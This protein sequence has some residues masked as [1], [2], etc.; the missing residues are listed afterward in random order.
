MDADLIVIGGGS[1]GVR[2]ARVA[3]EHG[4]KVVIAEAD[5]W[6]GTCVIRGCI[7]KKL[8]V[9]AAALG[10]DIEDAR[11]YGW[12][13]GEAVNDMAALAAAVGAE[14]ERL[15]QAY[16]GRLER[17][18][19]RLVRGRA[20]VVGP[21]EVEVDGARVSAGVILVAT[22][23]S[24]E[25]LEGPGC[26][27]AIDSDDVFRMRERPARLAVVGGGYIAVELAHVFRGLGSAVHLIHRGAQMLR[28]FDADVRAAVTEGLGARGIALHLEQTLAAAERTGQPVRPEPFG[29]AQDRLRRAE[30]PAESKDGP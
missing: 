26:D 2:A 18:G 17:A 27:V 8:M 3:A 21:H 22:G 10:G 23:A 12:Q 4:A 13:M 15:S 6:G 19:C 30:G 24:P 20:R 28:G 1:A 7:P 25:R 29:T 14:V 11:A 9:Y 5:R 16:A